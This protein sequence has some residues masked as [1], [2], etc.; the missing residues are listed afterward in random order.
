MTVAN[1]MTIAAVMASIRCHGELRAWGMVCHP[2]VCAGRLHAEVPPAEFE[3]SRRAVTG[4]SSVIPH[5]GAVARRRPSVLAAGV[6]SVL[7]LGLVTV[8]P[9]LANE[10]TDARIA[11]TVGQR[12]ADPALGDTVGVHVMDVAS[13]TRVFDR[14]ASRGFIP[15]STIKV[16]TAYTSARQ[17]GPDHRFSTT[18]HL[19]TS[20]RVILE[21][22]GDPI[23]T[24][25]DLSSLAKKVKRKLR[26]R[27]LEGTLIVDFD[28]D[29]FGTPV[30]APGWEAGD[31]PAY[32]SAV[33]G[34]T[35]L[36]SYSTDTGRITAEAFVAAL[37]ERRIDARLGARVDVAN[38]GGR[39][40]R[41]RGNTVADAIS[42]MM[43]PSENNIAEILFRHVALDT[44]RPTTW[45]G[46]MRATRAVLR[47][48]GFDTT[49]SRFVDGSGLSYDNR[50]TPSLLTGIL[51]RINQDAALAGV[52]ESLPTAGVNGTLARRFA[53]APASCAR[54]AV[55]AKTGSL[56]MTVSTLAGLTTGTDGRTRAF[57]IMVNERPASAAW[58]ATSL[59]IDTIAAAVHGCVSR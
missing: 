48:D 13:G 43:P 27:G 36:G 53:Y 8:S 41:F 7:A 39:L 38:E 2:F 56:P 4:C 5:D 52:R 11:A 15:A 57:A 10:T 22:G 16:V 55:A 50:V 42:A 14:Q 44:G 28:D 1:A 46:A 35:L 37:R 45:I 47:G 58:S 3:D 49:G 54:G 23:L 33:R 9:A 17:L 20:S 21:G 40:A 26:A 30:N 31:M 32:I 12:V 24:R 29:L 18:V 59:A 6:A 51:A 25:Q 19:D 34:L